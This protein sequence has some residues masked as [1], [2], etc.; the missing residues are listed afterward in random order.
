MSVGVQREA[1]GVVTQHTA[2]GF[3]VH[4]ILEG[5]GGKGVSEVMESDAGQP[6][7]L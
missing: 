2:D 4:A 1:C 7:S 6:C 5:H 3:Y